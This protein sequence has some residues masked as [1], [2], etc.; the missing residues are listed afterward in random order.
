MSWKES[1][2]CR[3]PE[4]KMI[5]ETK[6]VWIINVI[7]EVRNKRRVSIVVETENRSKQGAELIIWKIFS[8]RFGEVE[9]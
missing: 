3:V 7:D 6:Y 2:N 5:V 9:G 4:I 1:K 8:D